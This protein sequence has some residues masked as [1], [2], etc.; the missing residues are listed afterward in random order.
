MRATSLA[1]ARH[2]ILSLTRPYVRRYSH[3][4]DNGLVSCAGNCHMVDVSI[5]AAFL[6]DSL[7][8]KDCTRILSR[9]I[10]T[11]TGSE[12]GNTIYEPCFG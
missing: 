10:G 11:V 6:Y 12:G 7:M 1:S 9:L 2:W 8:S 5:A 3:E 4:V